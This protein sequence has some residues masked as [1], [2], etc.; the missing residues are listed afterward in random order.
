[1]K[2]KLFI[3]QLENEDEPVFVFKEH[4]EGVVDNGNWENALKRWRYYKTFLIL[5]KKKTKFWRLQT[6]SY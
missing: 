3:P 5:L 6:Y 4:T 2:L 1:M